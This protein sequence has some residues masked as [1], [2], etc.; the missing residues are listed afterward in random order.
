MTTKLVA[1]PPAATVRLRGDGNVVE[2]R[3]PRAPVECGCAC[4][5]DSKVLR[6]DQT[7][8]GHRHLP[9]SSVPRLNPRSQHRIFVGSSLSF[10]CILAELLFSPRPAGRVPPTFIF[11]LPL[12]T[13]RPDHEL[14]W[15]V[16][17][18]DLSA[19]H[20]LQVVPQD[21]SRMLRPLHRSRRRTRRWAC[22]P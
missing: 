6:H 5:G 13:L 7:N 4:H 21:S 15:Q 18:L 22:H 12:H 10:L 2:R 17:F 9:E 19:T 16:L 1:A 11:Q 14:F 3:Y 20:G 8:L